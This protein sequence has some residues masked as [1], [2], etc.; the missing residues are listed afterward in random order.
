M[1]EDTKG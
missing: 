1:I